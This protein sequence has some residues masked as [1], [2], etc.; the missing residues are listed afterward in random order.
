M[1]LLVIEH[2]VGDFETFKSVF[3]EDEGRRRR[4]GPRGARA[5]TVAGEPNN[6]RVVLDFDSAEQARKHAE[7][8][9]LHEAIKWA[10]G[11]VSMPSFG[12]L[13]QVMDADA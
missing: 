11:N 10:T 12:V 3:T 5:Y 1:A 2:I 6:V 4:G 13:E 9:E 7:G 8:L